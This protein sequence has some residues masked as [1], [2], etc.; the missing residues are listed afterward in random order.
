MNDYGYKVKG[1]ERHL[2]APELNSIHMIDGRVIRTPGYTSITEACKY[3]HEKK[4]PINK[5]MSLI[6]KVEKA[7]QDNGYNHGSIC[8]LARG[9]NVFY[10]VELV[11]EY[12]EQC[13]SVTV[14][15]YPDQDRAGVLILDKEI[16]LDS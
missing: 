3:L 5:P 15:A 8:E 10:L 2:Y 4:I 6:E 7:I 14:V 1:L 9:I 11:N 12:G 16:K 13:G